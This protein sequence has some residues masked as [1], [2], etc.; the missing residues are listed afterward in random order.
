MSVYGTGAQRVE[1]V[2]VFLGTALSALSPPVGG[3]CR[4][5][6]DSARR[7]YLTRALTLITGIQLPAT[8]T[9]IRH[10]IA[11]LCGHG[12]LTVCPSGAAFAIPLGPTN[13]QLIIMAEETLVFRRAGVSPALWLLVPAFSLLYAPA[14]VTPLPSSR[15]ERSPTAY[16]SRKSRTPAV[17]ARHLTPIIFGART[18]DE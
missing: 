17:S 12:I 11:S 14:W 8:D 3:N 18:L 5:A 15:T 6:R 7:I 2:E 16:D 1:C 13:P 10:S 4:S 9:A